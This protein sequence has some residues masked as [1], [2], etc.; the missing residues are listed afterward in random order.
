MPNEAGE[1]A[2]ILYDL[3]RSAP[4]PCKM[5]GEMGKIAFYSRDEQIAIAAQIIATHLKGN[6]RDLP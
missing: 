3:F 1:L 2:E 6:S 4:I 5:N